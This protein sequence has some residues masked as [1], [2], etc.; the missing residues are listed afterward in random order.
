MWKTFSSFVQLASRTYNLSYRDAEKEI[1]SRL[2]K[3]KLSP[4]SVECYL[5]WADGDC[6]TQKKISKRLN[7]NQGTVARELQ[8]IKQVWPQL[9]KFGVKPPRFDVHRERITLIEDMNFLDT[10]K[11]EKI[12]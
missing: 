9:F 4:R 8:H 3:A 2:V 12:A 10:V 6:L 11:I 7:I 1:V 5:N